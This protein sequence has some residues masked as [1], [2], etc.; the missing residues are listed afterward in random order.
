MPNNTI[1]IGKFP[2]FSLNDGNDMKYKN[3]INTIKILTEY[4]I[5]NN[6]KN[7]NINEELSK[8]IKEMSELLIKNNENLS[9]S[10]KDNIDL[11]QKNNNLE[12]KYNLLME[13]N[14]KI[15][16]NDYENI[17]EELNKKNQQIKSLEHMVARL[18]NKIDNN[19]ENNINIINEDN[20]INKNNNLYFKEKKFVK[21]EKNEKNLRKFLD[22]FTNGEYSNLGSKNNNLNNLKEEI[23]RISKK[24]NKE[25]ENIK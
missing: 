2:T 23:E 8:R 16:N 6:A 18:T 5:T 10:R 25:L 13:Q 21:N 7:N 11:K 3:I 19:E 9:K 14:K 12:L 20:S 1:N 15:N 17:K 24:I 22:K 4:I